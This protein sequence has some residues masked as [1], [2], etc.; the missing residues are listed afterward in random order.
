MF[1]GSAVG[2]FDVHSV[3]LDPECMLFTW[4]Q[5]RGRGG[6]WFGKDISLGMPDQFDQHMPDAAMGHSMWIPEDP[7]MPPMLD[8]VDQPTGYRLL[9][10]DVMIARSVNHTACAK[11]VIP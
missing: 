4:V 3:Q 10:I 7:C 5:W 1:I 11:G 6:G 8:S 9:T 2:C